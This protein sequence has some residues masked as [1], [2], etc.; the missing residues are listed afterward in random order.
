MKHRWFILV[1]IIGLIS[2]KKNDDFGPQCIECPSVEIPQSSTSPKVFIVNEG[3][4]TWN[5]A[6][7]SVLN[8]DSSTIQNVNKGLHIMPPNT[9]HI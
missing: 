5:N 6:S 1:V 2:C 4:Y 3:V 8:L 7:L 9:S